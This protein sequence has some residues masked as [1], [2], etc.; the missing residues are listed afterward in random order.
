M[1]RDA[2]VVVITGAGSGIGAALANEAARSGAQ[3]VLVG[4]RAEPL[5]DV[6]DALG[7]QRTP[8]LVQ[9]DVTTVEGRRL[10]REACMQAGGRID[11]LF[12]NAGVVRTGSVSG[13][14]DNAVRAMIETNLMAPLLLARD[15]LPMLRRAKSPRIVNIGSMFGDIA[16]PLFAVYSATK[17]GLRGLSDALRRELKP[18]GI[19]ITYAAPRAVRTPASDEF[20]ELV[21]PFS[22]KLDA[23]EKVARRIWRG[24]LKG[25]RT[26]YPWPERLF[27]YVQQ[28]LPGAVDN[29]LGKQLAAVR[30]SSPRES[31][32]QPEVRKNR[33]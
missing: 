7:A 23:P 32:T 33:A 17:F 29:G 18:E 26:I 25:K 8:I 22:M 6:A 2:R 12:N 20:A 31:V 10:L 16:F 28:F 30:S 3:L 9:A 5:A 27:I 24:A 13:M 19:G 1:Q 4:R 15:L 21:E 11:I 14:D